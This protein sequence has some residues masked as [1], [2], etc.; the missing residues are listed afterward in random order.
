M[1]SHPFASGLFAMKD[2][3]D[4]RHERSHLHLHLPIQVPTLVV[5]GVPKKY[6]LKNLAN[7]SRTIKR[8]DIK[9]YTLVTHSIIHKCGKFHYI[10]YRIDKIMLL[11]VRAI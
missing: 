9:V 10:I 6:P 7:F 3:H 5:P 4:G 1:F 8:Y 2:L 11:L